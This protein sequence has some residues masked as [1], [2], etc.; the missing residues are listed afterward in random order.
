MIRR[1]HTPE[2]KAKIGESRRKYYETHPM[3]QERIERI[4]ATNK[5]TYARKKA[6]YE[7]LVIGQENSL[8]G[9]L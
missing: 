4:K 9:L 3:P 8:G 6:Y 1:P 2:T 5:A 7:S